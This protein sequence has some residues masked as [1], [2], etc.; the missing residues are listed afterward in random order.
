MVRTSAVVSRAIA[1]LL[2]A[3]PHL[4]ACKIWA[5]FCD[6]TSCTENCGQSVSVNDPGCLAA[7][8]SRGSVKLHGSDFLGAYLVHSPDARC[9]CQADCTAIPGTGGPEC[10]DLSAK[11]KS[12]SY[13]FQLTTCKEVEGGPGVGNNCPGTNP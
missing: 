12:Q 3:G 2:A 1:L 8:Y 13:R 4:G 11:A 5:Q 7:E 9:G 10:I 6:D